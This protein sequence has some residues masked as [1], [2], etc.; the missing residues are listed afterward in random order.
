MHATRTAPARLRAPATAE[1]YR[2]TPR[3]RVNRL[4]RASAAP[5]YT[6][7]TDYV[8]Q[9]KMLEVGVRT[10]PLGLGLAALGRP[11]YINIGHDADI[12]G[13]SM[14]EM[15]A[16]AHETL[17]AAWA[18]GVRYFDCARSY[19]ASEEFLSSWLQSRNIPHDKI[20]VGSK[21]GYTYT[22]DWRVDT[23]GEAHEV[24]EHTA[25]NLA[26]QYP[27]SADLL[28]PYLRL[29][30]I[31][32]AT[33]ESGVLRNKDVVSKLSELKASKG[34]KIGLTL[35]GVEQA[36]VLREAMTVTAPDGAKLFDCV[37][38]TWNVM[39]QSAG[40]ALLEA[41][42]SGME[43]IVKEALANGRLSSRNPDDKVLPVMEALRALASDFGSPPGRFDSFVYK[44]DSAAIA[45]AMMQGFQPMVLS[46]AATPHQVRSNAGALTLLKY[47]TNAGDAAEGRVRE[48]LEMARQDPESYWADRAALEWN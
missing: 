44:A 22:A 20:V 29:Y 33:A 18:M 4:T 36:D 35:S 6:P 47:L 11:G 45:I 43:V 14:D 38:A 28:D 2:R 24:K 15:R 8:A 48:I 39:E 46:G 30:Q 41:K 32:S 34:V 9:K 1:G 31:H 7:A 26:R 12:K 3:A 19:G 17:D 40:A 25:E 27:E 10:P 16:H 37:Q 21:W 5:F 13:K 42:E 23:A